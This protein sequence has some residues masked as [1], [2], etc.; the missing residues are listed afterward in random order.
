MPAP[1]SPLLRHGTQAFAPKVSGEVVLD[2]LPQG[3]ISVRIELPQP[4]EME[5][6]RQLTSQ[7]PIVT[8][9]NQLLQFLQLLKT[10]DCKWCDIPRHRVRQAITKLVVQVF[11]NVMRFDYAVGCN[12]HRMDMSDLSERNC[13]VRIVSSELRQPGDISG[14]LTDRFTL[15]TSSARSFDEGCPQG[16]SIFFPVTGHLL[17]VVCEAPR[18][19][20]H[21]QPSVGPVQPVNFP[22]LPAHVR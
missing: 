11:P 17:C 19:F 12:H 21:G 16:L 5:E 13:K 14:E 22:A 8:T 7:Y 6:R 4:Q 18:H 3:W 1:L 9:A 20:N 15:R 10:E 2:E